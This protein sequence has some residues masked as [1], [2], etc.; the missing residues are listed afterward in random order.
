MSEDRRTTGAI[1]I[2]PP[3]AWSE[4]KDL[5]TG[6]LNTHHS[7][8]DAVLRVLRDETPTDGGFSVAMT[9]DAIIAE[10]ELSNGYHLLDNVQEFLTRYAE[11]H[12]FDGYLESVGVGDGS[13]SR[14]VAVNAT[15]FVI[16]PVEVWP[17]EEPSRFAGNWPGSVA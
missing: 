2:T 10:R 17:N 15:A 11:G 6:Y 4:V 13:K 12:T 3:L 1:T 16:E 8:R 14:I 7:Q 5:P 9:C